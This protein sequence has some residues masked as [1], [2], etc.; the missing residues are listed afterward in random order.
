[1]GVDSV[2]LDVDYAVPDARD[3]VLSFDDASG[4]CCEQ[5]EESRFRQR[6]GNRVPVVNVQTILDEIDLDG[7]DA[8]PG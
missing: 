7:V 3:D 1:M 2:A 6:Q 5:V 4:V 8:N